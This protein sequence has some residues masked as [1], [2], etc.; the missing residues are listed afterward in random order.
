MRECVEG[1]GDPRDRR[2]C[3]RKPQTDHCEGKSERQSD[4]E[5]DPG[6]CKVLEHL[7]ADLVEVIEDPS[8]VDERPV[9]TM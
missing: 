5:C 8:P 2:V 9:I 1:A 6:E 3:A 7:V 4:A